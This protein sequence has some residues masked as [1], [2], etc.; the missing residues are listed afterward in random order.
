MIAGMLD[1]HSRINGDLDMIFD[2]E[3]AVRL[4]GLP[5]RSCSPISRIDL[6]RPCVLLD[7]RRRFNMERDGSRSQPVSLRRDFPC[8]HD[9]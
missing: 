9:V 8:G 6:L 5:S 1:F 3:H 2:V 7:S 4:I